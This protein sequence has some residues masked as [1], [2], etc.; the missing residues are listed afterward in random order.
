MMVE[1]RSGVRMVPVPG[2]TLPVEERHGDGVMGR[3]KD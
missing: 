1:F 3:C 2:V